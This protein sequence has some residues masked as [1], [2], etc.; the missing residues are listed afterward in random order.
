[1]GKELKVLKKYLKYNHKSK[2]ND[3]GKGN[4]FCPYPCRPIRKKKWGN[5]TWKIHFKGTQNNIMN[6]V[7]P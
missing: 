2:S 3:K 6:G 7:K 4:V 1:M 5:E